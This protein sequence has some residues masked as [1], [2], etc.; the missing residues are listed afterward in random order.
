MNEILKSVAF[1]G[2][3]L[4]IGLATLFTKPSP[5]IDQGEVVAD[6]PLFPDFKNPLAAKSLEII[7][8][9]EDTGSL[10]PFKVAQVN[11]LWSIP[12]HSNYPADAAQQM[13]DA[14][15]SLID[16]RGLG[17][18]GREKSTH[19]SLGVV[20]PK[21]PDLT[22][23]TTGVGKR[24]TIEDGKG[25]IL[26]QLII[27]KTDPKQT[28]VRY[29]RKPGQD[30]VYRVEMATDKLSTKFDDWIEKDL[31][32]LNAFDVK[33]VVMSDYSVDVLQGAIA[34]RSLISVDYDSKD[35]KW[36][37]EDMKVFEPRKGLVPAHL[38]ADEEVNND[39]LNDLKTALDDLKII[40]VSRKP[41]GLSADLKVE[42]KLAKDSNSKQSLAEHGF[43]VAS[44]GNKVE[45][46]SNEGEARCGTTEGVEYILRFGQIAGKEGKKTEKD[47][48]A[49]KP[50]SE[51]SGVSRYILV[52]TRFN[53]DLIPKPEL[54]PLPE[55]KKETKPA[56]S[57]PESKSE[58]EKPKTEEKPAEK[59]SEPA[60]DEAKSEKKEAEDGAS[61]CG[62]P[63]EEEDQLAQAD[64]KAAAEKPADTKTDEAKQDE[65]KTTV[66]P[67]AAAKAEPEKPKTPEELERERI[68]SEN[69]RKQEEYEGKV[70][71]GQKK[72]TELNARF[73]DWYYII[74][75][76][77]YQKIHLKRD[78]VVK[79]KEKPKD[80]T[81]ADAAGDK[82]DPLKKFDEL[83]K[84]LE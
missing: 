75:D 19:E 10:V 24:V 62:P 51:G 76:A 18:A 5:A 7:D 36:K 69:K 52:T 80:E 56:E 45:L 9:D 16:M 50:E 30:Y 12:S 29:V 38:A 39:K 74:S 83:K 48:K 73:A 57:K 20:D 26:A 3:A 77:T 67:P 40:D 28:S 81:G 47:E 2:V 60:K 25:Q 1:V 32:K 37:L 44:L 43:Y 21:S 17:I 35:A 15:T 71:D 8:F 23:G 63:T 78:D 54:E 33:Q 79:K 42:D 13:A 65:P 11:G 84:G 46:F 31:L 34:Q 55:A 4:A 72:V 41:A 49:A 82:N 27:G 66:P 61:K 64:E 58:A 70:K 14:A 68:T 53:Q 6:A 59:K 22:A